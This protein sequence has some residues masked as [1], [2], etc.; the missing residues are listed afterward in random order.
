MP[1]K[2]FEGFTPLD[3][4]DVNEFL[5]DQAVMSFAGTAARGSALPSPNHG[6]ASW[7]QD[8]DSFEIYNGS[9][10]E[11][12]G[13]EPTLVF[14]SSET[15]S[16]VSSVSID[17]VFSA[18]Y[19]NYKVLVNISVSSVADSTTLNVRVRASGSDLTTSTAYEYGRIRVGARNGVPPETQNSVAD[20]L[21]PFGTM[22]SILGPGAEI[23]FYDPFNL[24]NTRV[25]TNV[26]G[27]SLELV[28]GIVINSLAYDGFTIFPTTGTVTG[29]IIV[30]GIRE[31]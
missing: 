12:A 20:G 13:I 11:S 8:S 6:M 28:G 2:V 19:T 25:F 16:G 21:I 10:W 29:T 31:S 24:N 18:D 1:R 5:I 15:F 4:E 30:Y 23:Y 27:R 22:N 14:L 17:D 3:A 9:S 7:L 26:T